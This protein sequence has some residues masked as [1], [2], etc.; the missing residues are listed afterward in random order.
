MKNSVVTT[1][2]GPRYEEEDDGLEAVAV[3]LFGVTIDMSPDP[4]DEQD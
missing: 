1:I 2:S 3:A 4:F